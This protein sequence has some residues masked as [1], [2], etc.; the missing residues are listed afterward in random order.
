MSRLYPEGMVV[1]WCHYDN[2]WGCKFVV[3]LYELNMLRFDHV[4]KFANLI[5]KCLNKA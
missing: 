2:L 1:L 4:I 3:V 5:Y